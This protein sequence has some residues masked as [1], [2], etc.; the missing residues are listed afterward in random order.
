MATDVKLTGK[1]RAFIAH[2]L[3]TMN[4]TEAARR[5]KYKGDDNTLASVASENLRKPKIRAAIDEALAKSAMS[6]PEVLAR[7]SAIA[8]GDM[9]QFIGLGESE[10]RDHPQSRLIKKYVRKVKRI[11]GRDGEEPVEVE[12]VHIELYPADAMLT[13]LWKH[14]QLAAGKPTE[15]EELTGAGGKDLIDLTGLTDEQL[16][17]LAS[18]LTD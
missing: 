16:R 9:G 13:Q 6:A 12:T 1:Q 11:P 10:L 4:G 15:R 8:A 17:A 14:H 18:G 2:Y 5:A 7:I 3:E